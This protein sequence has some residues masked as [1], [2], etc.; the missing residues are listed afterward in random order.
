MGVG[1]DFLER[2]R[3][4]AIPKRRLEIEPGFDPPL[5]EKGVDIGEGA[6]RL[7]DLRHRDFFVRQAVDVRENIDRITVAIDVK[8]PAE[9]AV[10]DRVFAGQEGARAGHGRRRV[11]RVDRHELMLAEISGRVGILVE[12]VLA[13][14]IEKEEGDLLVPFHRLVHFGDRRVKRRH[15]IVGQKARRQIDQGRF[16]IEIG[17]V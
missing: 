11:H 8:R 4:L 14:A 7:I 12:D 2:G 9:P 10:L 6:L 15:A 5:L 3:A 17:R 13:R 1:A 16:V